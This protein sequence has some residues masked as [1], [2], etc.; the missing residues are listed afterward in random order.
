[1]VTWYGG[2]AYCRWVGGRLPTE[3]EWEYAA[4]G[5]EGNIY[6]WGSEAPT[7]EL[8]NSGACHGATAPAAGLPDGASWC[9]VLGM[10]GNA[11]E[12]TVDR[13]GPYSGAPQENPMGAPDGIMRVLRGGGWH[14]NEWMARSAFRLHDTA[15]GGAVGCI[16]F[17]CVV[18]VAAEEAS[19]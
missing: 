7:C 12:W 10:A 1:M 6:P 14:A 3:A 18:P 2:D 8:A 5:P 11:W 16:G 19:E 17:R 4:R 13:F 15:P 9:G